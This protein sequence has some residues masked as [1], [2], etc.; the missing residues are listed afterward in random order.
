M[1]E[2]LERTRILI[3]EEA[4]ERLQGKKAFVAGIGGV[5]SYSAEI[6]AR[7]GIGKITIHDSDVVANSNINRQIVAL[8]STVGKKKV[9]VMRSRILDINPNCVVDTQDFFI[10]HDSV[11]TVLTENFD[12]VIDAID[13]LNCK[14]RFL[15]HAYKKGYKLY[16]SMGAGNKIDPTK[17]QS[18][19]LFHSENCRLAKM[20]RKQLRREGI[21]GGIQAV[22]SSEKGRP[23]HLPEDHSN[24]NR[25]VNGTISGI[26]ALFG[27]MLASMAIKD[28][29]EVDSA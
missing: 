24:T 21:T 15:V 16:S 7:A 12:F 8:E 14:I 1:N 5:G 9:E 4:V 27:V 18:G 6:L 28:V 26:P 22:W 23:P 2:F 11:S 17:I 19:D 25:A 3:G 29:I 20:L 10:T 13:V